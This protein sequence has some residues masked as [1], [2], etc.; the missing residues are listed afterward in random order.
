MSDEPADPGT[1]ALAGKVEDAQRRLRDATELADSAEKR[2]TAEIRALEAD[3][4]KE[5]QRAA[6][7][8]EELR[9]G[10]EQELLRER[11]AKEQAIAAA[12]E[13]LAEIEADAESAENRVKEAERRATE[14]EQRVVDA[15]AR[16]REAAAN[17]LRE[18]VT[19]IRREAAGR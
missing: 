13:R 19:A 17:W 11:Q 9:E 16:A 12:E 5:R 1:E 8:I 4:E 14:A 3:L 2:A 18:Q 10:H 7:S 6:E 15:E